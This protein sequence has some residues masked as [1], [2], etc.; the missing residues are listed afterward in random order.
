MYVYIYIYMCVDLIY[1]NIE[2]SATSTLKLNLLH[3]VHVFTSSALRQKLR[4]SSA[5]QIVWRSFALSFY[6]FLFLS[7]S[8]S[9]Y[10]YIYIY[11]LFHTNFTATFVAHKYLF[12]H[13]HTYIYTRM[14]VEVC[15]IKSQSFLFI[16][17]FSSGIIRVNMIGIGFCRIT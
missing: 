9:L 3:M 4:S 14:G 7:L 16:G 1:M 12:V 10:I 13:T 15:S 2:F 17:F 11:A 8:L 6:M 5:Q